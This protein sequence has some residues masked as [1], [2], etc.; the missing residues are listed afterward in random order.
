MGYTTEFDGH[1][2]LDRPLELNHAN[3]L[4]RFSET[5]R[6]KRNPKEL[7]FINDPIRER[8]GLPFGVE[9]EY[10]VGGGGFAGQ[11]H[12]DSILEYNSPPSTQPG[13]WCQWI[14]TDDLRGIQ[15]DENEKF[16]DYVE[17]LQYIVKNF[18][19]PWGYT[20]NGEVEWSG[21]E[22]EDIGKIVVVNND[23]T[24]KEGRVTYEL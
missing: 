20:L 11:D 9:G 21:E 19:I 12:D 5:R 10:F 22:R 3:Y 7:Q 17:W 1:F 6:M 18:L 8:V 14:P 13:L 24:V 4:Q 2:N 23:I 15:W 16:Y